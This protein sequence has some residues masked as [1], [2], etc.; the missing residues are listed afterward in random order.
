MPFVVGYG[1]SIIGAMIAYQLSKG[2][3][4]NTLFGE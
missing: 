4:E 3:N 2:K 1:I